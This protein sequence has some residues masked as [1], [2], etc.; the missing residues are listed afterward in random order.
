MSE[1]LKVAEVARLLRVNDTTVRRWVKGGVLE[2]VVLPH[3]SR[4]RQ[5]YR[6]H[7]ST[8]DRLLNSTLTS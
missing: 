3:V 1:L 8:L 2:A 7:R 6:V 5:V 4:R